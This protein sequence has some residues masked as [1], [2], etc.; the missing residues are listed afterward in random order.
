MEVKLIAKDQ[1]KMNFYF[2][3]MLTLKFKSIG[4]RIYRINIGVFNFF[5]I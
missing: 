4:R 2:G 5:F 3:T 1:K